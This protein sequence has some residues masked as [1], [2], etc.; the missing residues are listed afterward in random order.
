M[1]AVSAER[2]GAIIGSTLAA[3]LVYREFYACLWAG[4]SRIYLVRDGAI[5]QL[6]RDHTEAEELL[7][8]GVL[9]P[10]EAARW[11][12]RN[13]ITRAIGVNEDP[14]LEMV[15]GELRLNDTFLIC[16][17]GLTGYFGADEILAGIDGVPAQAA[18][19]QFLRQ[20]LER[21]AADNVTIVI[22]RYRKRETTLIQAESAPHASWG[23]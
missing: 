11:P 13:V 19:D 8:Q 5:A 4:D 17:D 20:T 18:C 14:E 23:K 3:L 9:T 6:T 2:G 12:R 16:S 10:E 15:H 1:L 7:E 21:G 22:V